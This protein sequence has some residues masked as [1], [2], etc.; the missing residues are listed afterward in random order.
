[1]SQEFGWFHRAKSLSSTPS[2]TARV[3]QGALEGAGDRRAV[4]ANLRLSR[5]VEFTCNQNAKRAVCLATK[6]RVIELAE[7]AAMD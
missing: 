1:M 6:Y 3:G 4:A 2:R 5:A 7:S